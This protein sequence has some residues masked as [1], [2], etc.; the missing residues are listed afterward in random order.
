MNSIALSPEPPG[1]PRDD[2]G[3][4]DPQFLATFKIRVV[5]LRDGFHALPDLHHD[6]VW[7]DDCR[8]LGQ[9]DPPVRGAAT[10]RAPLRWRWRTGHS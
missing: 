2:I 6:I 7:I 8:L 3:E 5:A 4:K 1:S 9:A 10:P